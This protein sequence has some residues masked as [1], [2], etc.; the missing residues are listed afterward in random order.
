MVRVLSGDFERA[1]QDI[2]RERAEKEMARIRML[3]AD[4][5]NPEA[6]A[7]IAEEI[8]YVHMKTFLLLRVHDTKTRFDAYRFRTHR[9]IKH[10]MIF[11][12]KNID[13]NME[14]AMEHHPEAFGTVVMLYINCKVRLLALAA[15]F[16]ASSRTRVVEF[17]RGSSQIL[18]S[19]IHH[20]EMRSY[21]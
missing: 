13:S 15:S 18:L 7:L 21:F 10:S 8:R 6:Q 19:T 5:F 3:T 2:Q 1:L 11:R 9:A 17:S 16:K 14:A 20:R 4:P 12:Q